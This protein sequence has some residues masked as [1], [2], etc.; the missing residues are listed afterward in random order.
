ME[1]RGLAWTSISQSYRHRTRR[2]VISAYK[3]IRD[4]T[5]IGNLYRLEDPHEG[6]RGALDFVSKD[7]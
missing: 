6:Y 4:V 1:A 3:Q 5:G 7:H 2:Y